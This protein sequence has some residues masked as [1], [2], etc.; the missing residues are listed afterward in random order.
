M[1]YILIKGIVSATKN[2]SNLILCILQFSLVCKSMWKV[3]QLNVMHICHPVHKE[4]EV[5]L[6]R[7]KLP[8]FMTAALE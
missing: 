4:T 5:F 8:T 3:Q 2:H 6:P 1:L 7:R